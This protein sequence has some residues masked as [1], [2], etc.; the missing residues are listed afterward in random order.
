MKQS[1]KKIGIGISICTL[2]MS[3][4]GFAQEKKGQEVNFTVGKL[5]YQVGENMIELES[6][7]F[8]KD[9]RTML[10]IKYVAQV[11][12]IESK[13]IKWNEMDQTITIFKGNDII[14]MTLGK[15]DL[16]VGREKV[17]MNTA[18]EM[19][20]GRT[21]LP[22]SYIAKALDIDMKWNEEKQTI[23]FTIDKNE[24]EFIK[25]E[26]A[27]E[28]DYD[29]L[30]A[31]AL[32][33][34]KDLRKKEMLVDKAEEL[35][36]D[37]TDQFKATNTIP[38]QMAN[39]PD[40]N[41]KKNL[42]Y[43]NFRGQQVGVQKAE[44][45]LEVQKEKIAY[46][47]QNAYYEILKSQKNH[48]LAKSA[49]DFKRQMMNNTNARYNQHMV[50]EIENNM[51]KRDYEESKKTYDMSEKALD[52][53]YE[54]M[55][56]LAGLDPNERYTLKDKIEF[57]QIP[58]VDLNLNTHIPY[59]ISTSPQIWALEQHIDLAQLGMDL[60]VFNYDGHYESQ[61]IDV[62][63]LRVDLKNLKQAYEENLRKLHTGLEVL[64][65]QHD[66]TLIAYEKAQDDL[67]LARVNV[68]V[69]TGI[70]I[71]RQ[72][73]QLKVEELKNKL[74]EIVMEYNQKAI[75]YEKPWLFSEV[76]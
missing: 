3:S 34:S 40:I 36:D 61:K 67:K 46:D 55:N 74:D 75:L 68:E 60:F 35:K 56:Y 59:K 2:L 19:R 4:V 62:E 43:R 20:R 23:T 22:V 29:K 10:P 48:Q 53:S 63:T 58:E 66:T 28:Y 65:K 11:I 12:G 6:A 64:K 13:N 57:T 18:P 42:T 44:K 71:Q 76:M 17:M 1:I 25:E 69:G 70:E 32:K 33:A 37:A 47:V 52:L 14:Q 51:A 54:K 49:M 8:I 27:F 73:A 30:L 31:K 15:N 45:D 39:N 16:M 72:G 9:G 50:S 21:F 5:Q 24:K 41:G 26:E 7:P 38:S